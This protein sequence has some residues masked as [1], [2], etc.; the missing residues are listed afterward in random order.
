MIVEV[1]MKSKKLDGNGYVIAGMYGATFWLFSFIF[2]FWA[3]Q[4]IQVISPSSLNLGFLS[5]PFIIGSHVTYDKI[6]QLTKH[7]NRSNEHK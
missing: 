5:I 7:N 1:K 6:R 3:Y 4:I 2:F